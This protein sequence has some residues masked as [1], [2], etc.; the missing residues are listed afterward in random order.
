MALIEIIDP[1]SSPEYRELDE[2]TRY[3]NESP[4]RRVRMH[5]PTV[6]RAQTEY[7]EKLLEAGIVDEEL[8]EYVMVAVAQTND[9][10]YCAGSHRLKLQTIAGVSESVVEAMADGDYEELS[11]IER[12]VVEFAEQVTDDPHR[13]AEAHLEA[14]YEVGFEESDVIQLLAVIGKCNTANLIVS[15]LNITPDDRSD[16]LPSY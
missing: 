4:Y 2:A 8:F 12:A 10:D 3:D 16:D 5:N 1:R 11:E 7:G 13:V 14:L 15:A 9:C 6:L